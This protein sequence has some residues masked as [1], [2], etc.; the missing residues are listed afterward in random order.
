MRIPSAG[1]R[2]VLNAIDNAILIVRKETG[3]IS[4]A[5]PSSGILL[6]IPFESIRGR[7]LAEVLPFTQRDRNGKGDG[8]R[9][10]ENSFF[11]MTLTDGT[12]IS[13]TMKTIPYSWEG[14]EY[15]FVVLTDM[16]DQLEQERQSLLTNENLKRWVIEAEQ[17]YGALAVLQELTILLQRCRNLEEVAKVVS[18]FMTKILPKS[19]GDL[20]LMD[21]EKKGAR[22]VSAW[23][24]ISAD[25]M[26]LDVERCAGLHTGKT[27][28]IRSD[29][30]DAPIC[31]RHIAA[32]FHMSFCIPLKIDEETIGVLHVHFDQ[33]HLQSQETSE[34][35]SLDHERKLGESAANLLSLSIANAML[36][37]TLLHQAIRDPLTGLFN[38]RYLEESMAREVARATRTKNPLSVIMTDI[39]HFKVFNDQFGHAA[40]DEVL[41]VVSDCLIN[42]V[43]GSD[44][45]CRFG[46]EE[47]LIVLQDAGLV[48]AANRAEQIRKSVSS[49]PL[50]FQGKNLGYVTMSFGVSEF[51]IHGE[52]PE[53]FIKEA[54][55]A[56]YRAKKEG[57]NRVVTAS[58]ADPPNV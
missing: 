21:A 10:R 38:R 34:D 54:D 5:N 23:G 6:G 37:E 50:D 30:S 39:D 46:G 52:V 7:P 44:I 8:D 22:T 42:S 1:I 20:V 57:R 25:P 55:M 51:P 36:R 29:D 4:F 17:R 11:Q 24:R 15:E 47:F 41:R 18:S 16:T 3:E 40:G 56:L 28:V 45:V 48:D 33:T 12:T 13:V 2:Y 35:N 49:I 31:V 19:M 27:A 9:G 53:R 26:L 43:R 14:Q 32:R 58:V